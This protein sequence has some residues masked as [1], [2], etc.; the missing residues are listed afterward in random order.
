M[1]FQSF[2]PSI[3][4]DSNAFVFDETN[5][6]VTLQTYLKYMQQLPPQREWM[7]NVLG[8]RLTNLYLNKKELQVLAIGTGPG[9]V[10]IDILNELVCRGQQQHGN[11]YHL[12]Y[13]VVEPNNSSITFFKNRVA[14]D[15]RYNRIK[16]EWHEDNFESFLNK[17]ET[18][19][20]GK[21][22]F[23][24]FV[25]CFYYMDSVVCLNQTYDNLISENGIIAVVGE[26]ENAFWPKMMVFLDN[27][28]MIHGSFGCSGRVSSNYFL[29]GWKS[30]ADEKGWVYETY[31]KK[32]NFDIT[33]MYDE[34]S[35]DGNYLID[36]SLHVKCA[37]K[38]TNKDILEDFFKF[39]NE[40]SIENEE[41]QDGK[42]IIK[43]YFPCQLGAIIITKL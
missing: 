3:K 19:K 17:F 29:P 40:N 1:T 2:F 36:F 8:A 21:F 23:I 28:N 5:Y 30:L 43:R 20:K 4:M 7:K 14:G 6:R 25:R 34:E 35:I 12:V 33:P 13:H 24:H 11:E 41:I 32:Y 42:K 22:D 26:N 15:N 38:T 27:H 10:D 37:R 9:D 16:F 39:L 18:E 31:T